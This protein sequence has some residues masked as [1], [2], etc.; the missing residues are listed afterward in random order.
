MGKKIDLELIEK[1]VKMRKNGKTLREISEEVGFT[2]AYID[3][4]Y[5]NRHALI[6][7]W[8]GI[9]EDID[10]IIEDMG[11]D[12]NTKSITFKLQ[13]QDYNRYAKIKYEII[14]NLDM[15]SDEYV[16]MKL[17]DAYDELQRIKEK[18]REYSDYLRYIGLN[19]R[20]IFPKFLV[21]ALSK[22]ERE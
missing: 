12:E 17:L 2:P 11:E 14:K 19:R 16:F 3:Y 7:R 6:K 4:V 18:E 15:G 20:D 22:D 13:E 10:K 5:K 21:E 1:I 8:Y 9:S